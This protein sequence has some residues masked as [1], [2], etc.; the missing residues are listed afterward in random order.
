MIYTSILI[1]EPVHSPNPSTWAV[2]LYERRSNKQIPS[3][4]TYALIYTPVFSLN[5]VSR[6]EHQC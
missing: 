1:E 4:A 3:R 5:I 6:C 2:E